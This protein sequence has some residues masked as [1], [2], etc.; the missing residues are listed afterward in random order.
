MNEHGTVCLFEALVL[1]HSKIVYGF[2]L[3]TT[4]SLRDLLLMYWS[5]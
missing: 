4:A 5:T 3:V 2:W 1:A